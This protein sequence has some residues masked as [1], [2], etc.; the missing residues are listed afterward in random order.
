MTQDFI[1]QLNVI[2][3]LLALSASLMCSTI[4]YSQEE[5]RTTQSHMIIHTMV[6]IKCI[7][8]NMSTFIVRSV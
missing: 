8:L 5:I 1:P 3:E 4:C 6:A 7:T 2:P